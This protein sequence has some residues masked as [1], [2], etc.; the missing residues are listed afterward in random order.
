MIPRF[1]IHEKV[2]INA[3]LQPRA[4]P[5]GK[6]VLRGLYHGYMQGQGEDLLYMITV[7]RKS[8]GG[9]RPHVF[10]RDPSQPPIWQDKRSYLTYAQVLDR[11]DLRPFG[12]QTLWDRQAKNASKNGDQSN[13]DTAGLSP[14]QFSLLD[15]RTASM[16]ATLGMLHGI[17]QRLANVE[18]QLASLEKHVLH[19][20]TGLTHMDKTL[21]SIEDSLTKPQKAE[22]D[23]NTHTTQ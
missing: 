5:D 18:E 21:H 4:D 12:Y 7:E 22:A 17:A 20:E 23:E 9:P 13:P 10:K 6:T 1:K 3:I 14:T 11:F 2:P 15:K 19:L 16:L 8:A